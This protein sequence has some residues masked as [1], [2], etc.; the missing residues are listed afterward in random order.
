MEFEHHA[1]AGDCALGEDKK[2]SPG[3]IFGAVDDLLRGAARFGPIDVERIQAVNQ[4]AQVDAAAEFLLAHVSR[5]PL[6]QIDDRIQDPNLVTENNPRPRVDIALL[7]QP[8]NIARQHEEP[9]TEARTRPDDRGFRRAVAEGLEDHA[10]SENEDS[11]NRGTDQRSAEAHRR[12]K[13]EERSNLEQP[14]IPRVRWGLH[15]LTAAQKAKRAEKIGSMLQTPESHAASNFHFLWTGDESWMFYE[16]DHEKIWAASWE[17]V[18]ELERTTHYHRKTI[19]TAFFN[20]TG[21][22]S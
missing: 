5:A 7:V 22:T 14:L 16:C 10:A 4:I 2:R 6:A 17:K 3:R 1:A 15:T 8:D 12:E 9:E 19:V 13:D 21:S 20:G 11:R 18:D